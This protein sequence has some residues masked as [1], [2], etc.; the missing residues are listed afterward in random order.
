MHTC[1]GVKWRGI[2]RVQFILIFHILIAHLRDRGKKK[3]LCGDG[4][5]SNRASFFCENI[6]TLAGPII[7]LSERMR[8]FASEK[9]TYEYEV[10]L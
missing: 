1:T 7:I 9:D 5:V 10:T 4:C 6:G 2:E 8:V 3:V